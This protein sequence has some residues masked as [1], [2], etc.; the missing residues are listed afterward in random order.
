M[1]KK[2]FLFLVLMIAGQTLSAG[3]YKW[4]KRMGGMYNE[5]AYSLRKDNQDNLFMAGR[6][7]GSVIFDQ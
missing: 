5:A 6:F 4:T 2:I 7:A 3:S 1:K